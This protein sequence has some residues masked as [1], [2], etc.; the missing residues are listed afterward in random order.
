MQGTTPGDSQGAPNM[1]GDHRV[2]E[3]LQIPGVQ[4]RRDGVLVG[5]SW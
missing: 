1:E 5:L 4:D 2:G 3:C